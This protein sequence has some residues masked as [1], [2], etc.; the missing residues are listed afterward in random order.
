MREWSGQH[1]SLYNIPKPGLDLYGQRFID[2]FAEKVDKQINLLVCRDCI[3][4]NHRS[5]Q[6]KVL[7]PQTDI[8]QLNAFK[9]LANDP[10]AN[11]IPDDIKASVPR[12]W[13]KNLSGTLYV[14][15]NKVYAVFDACERS[16]VIG[17]MDGCRYLVHSNWS[18]DPFKNLLPKRQMV[19]LC[20]QRKRSSTWSECGFYG[21]NLN[22]TICP[23]FS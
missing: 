11:G 6:I 15:P 14:L 19:N 20:R 3:H 2:S 1:N 12:D 18:Y 8:T 23:R 22:D 9:A 17:V 5:E 16:S 7:M 13:H 10:R 21:L 4:A